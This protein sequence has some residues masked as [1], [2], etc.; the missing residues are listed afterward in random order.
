MSTT[1]II[2]II[3]SSTKILY[4]EDI[5]LKCLPKNKTLVQTREMLDGEK[6]GHFLLM[7][8]GVVVRERSNLKYKDK[9]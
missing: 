6:V 9:S 3:R 7:I 2:R 5:L 1:K 8:S 4:L